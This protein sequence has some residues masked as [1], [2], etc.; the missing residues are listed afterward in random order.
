MAAVEEG[1][2]VL[3]AQASELERQ[4]AFGVVRQLFE[5]R[6]RR[7]PGWLDDAAA[8]ARPALDPAGAGGPAGIDA[9]PLTVLHGLYW[10]TVN[11][12]ADTPVMLVT[13]DV[14]WCDQASL[15]F[16]AYVGRRL[17]GMSLV[18]VAGLRRSE[19]LWEE[20]LVAEMA[21]Q[22]GGV[23]IEPAPLSEAAVAHLLEARL[24]AR[25]HAGFT[26]ACHRATGGNPLLLD[27]LARAMH[28]DGVRPDI[29]SPDVVA[30][31]GPRAVSR[32]VLLRLARLDDDAVA[33]AR[34]VAVLGEGGDLAV[35]SAMTGLPAAAIE[36]AGRA[37]IR[38]EILR[39]EPPLG[40]VHPLIRDAVY[41][42][43]SS[44]EREARHAQAAQLLRAAG[45]PAES[46]AAHASVLPPSGQR[47]VVESLH[48]AA[49]IAAQRG[50][51]V[52]AV[53]YLRRAIDEPPERDQYAQL[54]LELG[55]AEVMA[56]E[57]AP[58]AEHL[59]AAYATLEHDPLMRAR[60]AEILSRTML[61]TGQPE[62]VVAAIR[63]AQ[64]DLPAE[65]ADNRRALAAV[66]SFA[67][68]V[69]GPDVDTRQRLLD[70]LETVDGDGPG[71]RM[72]RAVLAWDLAVAGGTASECVRL[73]TAALGDGT[74]IAKD[75][76]FT[77]IVAASVLALADRD[78][79]L[80]VW[81]EALRVGHTRGFQLTVGTV[82]VWRG[83]TWLRRG[84][85]ADADEALRQ[86]VMATEPRA[87]GVAVGRAYAMAYLTLV[88]LEQGDAAGAHEA[89]ALTGDST[90][91]S[92]GDIQSR[93]AA[94]ELL[95]AEGSWADA[96]DALDVYR[97]RLRRV[98][99]PTWAPYGS[100]LARAL[101]GLGRTEDA[102]A[103]AADEVDAARRWGAPGTIGASLRALGTALDADGSPDCLTVLEE[104]VA[105]TAQSPAR[106]E[107]AKNLMAWGSALRRRG[108][109]TAAREP[110]ARAAELATVCGARPLAERAHDEVRAA[111]GRRQTRG[112]FGPD[113]LTPSERRVAALAAAGNTNKAIAQQ[114]F[115]T[116]KTVEVHLS[117]TY[118]KLGITS[119]S[120]LE[121]VEL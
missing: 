108:R 51:V 4:Y 14:Q 20:P 61:L 65:L 48:D 1:F 27:E 34:A 79:V 3:T 30:D 101:C 85:L 45:R 7:A 41:H 71:A 2:D 83:W 69:G 67:A 99:N 42:E 76:S 29:A 104:A 75:T 32:T 80:D 74:L 33:L 24:G 93:R 77:T 11:A 19:P 70:A 46:V 5:A 94:I 39:P 82:H 43:L 64:R 97:G 103:A 26:A 88:R 44:L 78:E 117:S 13:D 96:I 121:A 81:E 17:E 92:D 62:D 59:W 37:L 113:A 91:N 120:E 119:R 118:R 25:P 23:V 111:G 35:L 98:V 107:H 89:L 31:L 106:L 21:R 114:L 18:V 40:F 109:P 84:A 28:A 116:P 38:A 10:L 102:V 58:A 86:Y 63:R 110:L 54:V 57:P 36:T 16:L 55:M 68:N 53:S 115:V 50:G 87:G 22:P 8:S 47:W 56:I 6:V 60:I 52:S 90:P 66:E 100:L 95:L 49:R 105:A 72:V 73:A 112:V 12:C 9:G 15:R